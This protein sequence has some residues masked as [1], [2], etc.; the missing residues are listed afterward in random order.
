MASHLQKITFIALLL[1][2]GIPLSTGDRER[3]RRLKHSNDT[4]QHLRDLCSE[5][6]R[7]DECWNILKSA[8]NKFHDNSDDQY[9]MASVVTDLA[10]TKSKEIYDRVYQYYSNSNDDGLK[11]KYF[12]C[13]KNYYNANCN[14]VL[15]R[16][17]LEYDEYPNISDE[18]DDVEEELK[19]CRQNFREESFDAGRVK[20]QNE[21]FGLYVDIVR[22]AAGRLPKNEDPI[23]YFYP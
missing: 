21:E 11:K 2:I 13:S 5:T 12:S 17:N 19:I 16:R 14:L 20:G 15:A 6:K 1:T 22:A 3:S 8:L 18:L 4:E 9:F 7:S 23:K 10:I